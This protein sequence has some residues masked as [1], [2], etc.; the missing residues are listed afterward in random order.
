MRYFQI[1]YSTSTQGAFR[2]PF[3]TPGI[4]R[5]RPRTL[6]ATAFLFPRRLG[7][8]STLSLTFIFQ[9]ILLWRLNT[10]R[11]RTQNNRRQYNRHR[12]DPKSSATMFSPFPVV[13]SSRTVKKE[14]RNPLFQDRLARSPEPNSDLNGR[15]PRVRCCSIRK[16]VRGPCVYRSELHATQSL[17]LE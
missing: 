12:I 15:A 5:I 4:T 7:P 16:E 1:E 2:E 17:F 10:E 9:Q 11:A 3:L 8:R 6:F 14:R 13:H